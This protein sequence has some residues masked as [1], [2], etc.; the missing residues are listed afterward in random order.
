MDFTRTSLKSGQNTNL[1][2]FFP[3]RIS[4]LPYLL[5]FQPLILPLLAIT[6]HLPHHRQ[7][8][9][10]HKI[11]TINFCTH[12][13]PLNIGIKSPNLHMTAKINHGQEL[14]LKRVEQR[15]INPTDTSII[16]ILIKEIFLIFGRNNTSSQ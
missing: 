16:R 13:Q 11:H 4:S 5:L 1:L 3:R 15:Q 8:I 7:H 14:K 6:P 2:Y 10:L 12:L 9:L